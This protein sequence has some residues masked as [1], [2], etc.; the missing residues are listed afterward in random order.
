[1]KSSKKKINKKDLKAV[2]GGNADNGIKIP[3]DP[4][5]QCLDALL[6]PDGNY[7]KRNS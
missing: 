3:S 2:K 5:S 4:F 1:M 7:T 6:G